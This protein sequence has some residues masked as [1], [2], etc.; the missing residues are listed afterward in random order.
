MDGLSTACRVSGHPRNDPAAE[1]SINDPARLDRHVSARRRRARS[2]VRAAAL[3]RRAAPRLA[4]RG[5]A[6]LRALA[7]ALLRVRRRDHRLSVRGAPALDADARGE[8]PR[9]RRR[10]QPPARAADDV[11]DAAGARVGLGRHRRPH[12][13]VRGDDADPRDRDARRLRQPRPLPVL[14]LLGSD[15]DPDVLRHRGL[16]RAEPDLRRGE[17]R[18]LHDG[19]VRAHAGG[20]PRPLLP[21]RRRDGTVHV[22]PAGAGPVRD[23][24]RPRAGPHVPRLRPGLRDQGAAVPVPHLA[25]RRA[26]RGADRGQRDPGRRPPEDGDVRVPALL[27]AALPGREPR[28]RAARSSPWR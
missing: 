3:R 1:H 13:R 16:G 11:S 26:R 18:A 20:D 28:L 21:V 17:V 12:Q 24:A 9:R 10:H 7:A 23:G 25:P 6:H 19:R 14:R 15:A 8:L 22:R 4:R 2:A 27:P 5:A